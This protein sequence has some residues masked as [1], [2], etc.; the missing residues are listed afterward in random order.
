MEVNGFTQKLGLSKAFVTIQRNRM[1]QQIIK[2]KRERG[3][4]VREKGS[5]KKKSHNRENTKL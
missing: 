5:E 2:R 3:Q 1:L 4:N